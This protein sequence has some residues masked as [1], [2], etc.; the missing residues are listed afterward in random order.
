MIRQA[1]AP[2]PLDPAEGYRRWAPTY[3]DETAISD[4]ECRLVAALTPPL[5]G[6]RLL[7]AGCGTGRRLVGCGA[8]TAVGVD[9][10][11]A[12][13]D[14]GIGSGPPL[15]GVV[16]MVGDVRALPLGDAAFDVIWCRLV[17]GHLADCA[18]A[19]RELARVAAPDARVIVTDFHPAAYL[20]GHRRTF[21]E[22]D[23]V[24]EIEHHVHAAETQ[25]A[26]ARATGLVLTEE[27]AAAID[28]TVHPFYRRAGRD[29]LFAAHRGLPVV[30]ALAFRH[31]S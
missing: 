1:S 18:P 14:A 5:A 12:M 28:E 27:R 17:I 8:A 25:I 21:R 20:A 4:L 29:D 6:L 11:A 2:R 10:S 30:L 13:L 15:P 26:A 9:A 23:T 3:A 19:Y 31:E 22:G 7:D 24:H 16:T